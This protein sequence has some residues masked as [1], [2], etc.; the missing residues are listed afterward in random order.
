MNRR[1]FLKTSAG[2]AGLM[3]VSRY[4]FGNNLRRIS[5]F[6]VTLPGLGRD[7]ANNVGNYLP[8]LSPDTK[9]FPGTDYYDIIASQFTQTLHPSIGE[10]RF[11][12]YADAQTRDARYLGG[13]I[14]AKAG[15]PV[16]LR[17]TNQLPNSHILPMDP[18]AIELPMADE[19][20]KRVD[21]ITV[22]LHGGIV[23]P[24]TSDGGPASWF[25]NPNNPGGFTHGSSFLNKSE[26][27]SAIYD[28][29]NRQSSRFA[30]YHDHAYGV[31][32]LNAYAGLASAFLITDDEEARLIKEGVL[33]DVPGYSLGIPLVIQDKSF[34][35]AAH[36]GDYPVAGTRPGDLWYPHVYEA[37]EIPEMKLPVQCGKKGRWVSQTGRRHRSHWYP[38]HFSTRIL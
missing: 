22:H 12:G 11:W 14:V 9:T 28:Y 32:R 10:T 19:V 29:P 36:D 7:G 16:K 33:P 26:P 17:A 38:K 5:K 27:G 25:S 30:W 3:A 6:S 13:V 18:T 4:S 1:V 31:T 2:L 20:G 35:D 15:R 23:L 24:W 34:L 37:G 8:V 21:R